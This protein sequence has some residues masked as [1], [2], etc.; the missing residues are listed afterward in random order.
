MYLC[1]VEDNLLSFNNLQNMKMLIL[2]VICHACKFIKEA[3]SVKIMS[4]SNVTVI[5]F[6]VNVC[7]VETLNFNKTRTP[8]NKN[9][10]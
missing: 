8:T 10:S 5:N 6:S 7:N 1:V 2:T 9:Y 3:I 4:G